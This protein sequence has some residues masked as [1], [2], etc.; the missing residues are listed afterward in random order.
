MNWR[1]FGF[2]VIVFVPSLVTLL[3][4]YSGQDLKWLEASRSTFPL[5]LITSNF[6]N[7][8]FELFAVNMSL[9]ALFLWGFAVVSGFCAPSKWRELTL[10]LT[11]LLSAIG[12]IAYLTY[13][14]GSGTGSSGIVYATAGVTFGFGV[15]QRGWTAGLAKRR[16]NSNVMLAC[17]VL[18]PPAAFFAGGNLIVH[19]TALLLGVFV[20]LEIGRK[21]LGK[22]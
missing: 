8:D 9:F 11:A 13:L 3:L 19:A 21:S 5:S 14:G 20:G 4:G 1:L 18:G 2:F 6:V 22:A 17:L 15:V 16:L 10:A 7:R 12:G